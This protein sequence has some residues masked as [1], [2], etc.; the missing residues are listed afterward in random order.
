MPEVCKF[1]IYYTKIYIYYN[2][3]LS[4]IHDS[5]GTIEK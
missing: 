5:G 3:Y 2:A 4:F 1:K